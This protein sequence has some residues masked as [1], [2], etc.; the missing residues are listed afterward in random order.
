MLIW[1]GRRGIEGLEGVDGVGVGVE[2]E[3]W[4]WCWCWLEDGAPGC[5]RRILLLYIEI[6]LVI[7]FDL[8][9]N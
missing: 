4:C 7:W 1:G 6:N 9:G 2:K 3:V 5:W 8:S